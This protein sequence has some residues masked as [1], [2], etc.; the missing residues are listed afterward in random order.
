VGH[1]PPG[2][3]GFGAGSGSASADVVTSAS[4]WERA[5]SIGSISVWDTSGPLDARRFD[6]TALFPPSL[7]RERERLPRGLPPPPPMTTSTRREAV[8]R[9]S[10]HEFGIVTPAGDHRAPQM[11]PLDLA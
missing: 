10:W 11:L 1:E 5:V 7:S 9:G 2:P 8:R 6:I 3:F 4:M